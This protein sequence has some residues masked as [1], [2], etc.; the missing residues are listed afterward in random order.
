MQNPSCENDCHLH[1]NK[2]HSHINGYCTKPHFKTVAWEMAYL[3]YYLNLKEMHVQIH[4][5]TMYMFCM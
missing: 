3:F 5:Y 4:M 1:E 2:S